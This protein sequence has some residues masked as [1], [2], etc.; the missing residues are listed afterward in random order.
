MA[1]VL[2]EILA[3]KREEVEH[4]KRNRPLAAVR[5]EAEQQPAARG[6]VDA[7][8]RKANAGKP[9]VI[10]E[11]KKA[12][13][14]KGVIRE[15]F[16]PP[17]IARSFEAAGAAC[18]SVLTDQK[19]FQGGDAHLQAAR[20]TVALPVLRKDFTLDSY[21]VYEARALGAD[22]IL[23]IAGALGLERLKSLGELAAR[24]G[25][26]VLTEVHNQQELETALSLNPQMVGINNRNLKTFETSL[27]TTFDLLAAIPDGILV[28]TESGIHRR[29]DVTAMLDRDV[30]AFLVGEAF[31][32]VP[33]PGEALR[34]LFR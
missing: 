31:M 27:T 30:R 29:S 33:D 28:V 5:K 14:S 8:R 18:L 2:D 17:A 6:F 10:A 34:D 21:Q 9:A 19:Y 25:L 12:S 4:R 3:H 24:L 20:S 7:L 15:Q 32:R 11:I 22:C 23:L 26:D 16:D 1:T 13:P